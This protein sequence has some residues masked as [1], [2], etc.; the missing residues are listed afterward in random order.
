MDL[1]QPL[2]FIFDPCHIRFEDNVFGISFETSDFYEIWVT[3]TA[4]RN[5]VDILQKIKREPCPEN[6]CREWMRYG[7]VI[8]AEKRGCAMQCIRNEIYL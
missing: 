1:F 2:H 7:F 5:H 6:T 3:K 4:I 8:I